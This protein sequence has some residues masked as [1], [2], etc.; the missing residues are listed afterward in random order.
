MKW[1]TREQALAAVRSGEFSDDIIR[2]ADKVAVILTQSWCSQW[3]AMKNFVSDFSD[4]EIFCLEYDLADFFD[5]FREF[6]E[7]KPG[8]DLVPYNR[9]YRGGILVAKSNAVSEAGFRRKFE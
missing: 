3:H 1:I 7:N 2:S 6:K 9:H 8:N 5:V 4:A